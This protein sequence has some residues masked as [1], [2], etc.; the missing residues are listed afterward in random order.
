MNSWGNL[1]RVLPWKFWHLSTESTATRCR[2][3]FSSMTSTAA[4]ERCFSTTRWDGEK[5]SN[6]HT[7][8]R[9]VFFCIKLIFA[10]GKWSCGPFGS[11]PPPGAA[12]CPRGSICWFLLMR[13]TQKMKPEVDQTYPSTPHP[14][15]ALL[16]Y[17]NINTQICGSFTEQEVRG[18]DLLLQLVFGCQRK[19]CW[20]NMDGL[21]LWVTSF[22]SLRV[23]QPTFQISSLKEGSFCLQLQTGGD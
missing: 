3:W 19:A 16:L 23:G 1:R 11:T 18:P 7:L 14:F 9:E 10:T 20:H 13:K 17:L 21:H 5:N 22:L 8:A 6:L 4:A 2:A 12:C 15:F